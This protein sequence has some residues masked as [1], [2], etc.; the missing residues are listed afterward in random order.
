MRRA[1]VLIGTRESLEIC[2]PV[3]LCKL[4]PLSWITKTTM[5]KPE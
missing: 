1:K 5:V 4:S 2:L 3:A